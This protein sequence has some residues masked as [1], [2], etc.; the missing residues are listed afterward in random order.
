[1]E[2]TAITDNTD[3]PAATGLVIVYT[4]SGKG[5][6]TAAFGQALRAA[7]HGLKVCIIQFIKGSW[8]SGEARALARFDDL[9]ELHTTGTGFTWTSAPREV[10]LAAAAAWQLA[11]EKVLSGCFDLVI[12]DELTYL[13]RYQLLA[14]QELLALLARRPPGL[15]LV[16]T[17]RH[18]GP[19]LLAAAD[20]VTEMNEVKHPFQNGRPAQKGIEF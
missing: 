7:G 2:R 1:M 5:K 18:A 11:T 12:L 20:L 6:T 3:L 9:V 13:L 8:Q 14:E 15:H 4:G 10:A 19:G 16:I 17:G